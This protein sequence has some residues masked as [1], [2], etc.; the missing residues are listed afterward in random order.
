MRAYDFDETIYGGDST[1]DF[2]FYCLRKYP[3]ICLDLPLQGWHFFLYMCGIHTKTVFKEHFYRF[4]RRIPDIDAAVEDFWE[5]H[6]GNIKN[7]YLAQKRADDV[8][9][10]ASPAFLLE[11]PCRKL[12]VPAPI[13]SLVDKKTGA[14]TGENC[15]GEEK[16]RRF[17]AAFPDG[18][19]EAFY[20]DSLSDAPMAELSAESFVVSGETLLPWADY[21]PP[22]LSRLLHTFLSPSFFRFLLVGALNTLATTVFSLL[23]NR[24]IPAA[25]PAFAAG[26][27][28]TLLLSFFLNCY[29]T[30]KKPPAIGRLWKY[31]LSY[32]P[33]F[34]V[35]ILSVWV[36]CDIAHLP[37]ILSY[38]AAAIIGVPLTYILMK[39]FAFKK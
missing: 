18:E 13:A 34:L 16:P 8:I 28:T 9:I 15:Y 2:Y 26:Y 4:F 27:V 19:I 7:W 35:Q 6:F 12:G 37:E 32:I 10:S 3:K 22:L 21:T 17:A 39:L 14:Y 29:F 1:R 36:L 11:I 5:G 20:S 25:V 30:F 31:V 38:A 23:Y 24:I 33:N